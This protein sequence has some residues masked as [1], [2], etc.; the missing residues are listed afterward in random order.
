MSD[1]SRLSPGGTVPEDYLPMTDK[2]FAKNF[3]RIFR[4][5]IEAWLA[6]PRHAPQQ[7]VSSVKP[8]CL[9]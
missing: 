1:K 6:R 9:K 7:E 5:E 4:P 8:I 3:V 2:E